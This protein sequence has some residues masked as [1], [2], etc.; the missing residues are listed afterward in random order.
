MLSSARSAAALRGT[1]I[2]LFLLM[3]MVYTGWCTRV[4]EGRVFGETIQSQLPRGPVPPSGPAPCHN[5]V[6][7]KGIQE[8]HTLHPTTLTASRRDAMVLCMTSASLA[9][10]TLFSTEPA[11]ARIVKPEIRRKIM[12]KLEMLREKA[13]LSKPK[14]EDLTS[15]KDKVKT[16]P[17]VKEKIALK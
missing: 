4:M 2:L 11:E 16:P 6:R 14:S 13:G 10:A 12:E 8:Q 3:A 17:S 7:H 15:A 1:I 9:A 5:K